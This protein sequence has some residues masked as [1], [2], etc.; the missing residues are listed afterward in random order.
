MQ[1]QSCFGGRLIVAPLVHLLLIPST[2]MHLKLINNPLCYLTDHIIIREVQ[3]KSC[4]TLIKK[5]SFNF[6]EQ[7]MMK[8]HTLPSFQP[9]TTPS[10]R[11]YQF[12][13]SASVQS[14]LLGCCSRAEGVRKR[15]VAGPGH[16]SFPLTS[17]RVRD[18]KP[19][20]FHLSDRNRSL[21]R[22]SVFLDDG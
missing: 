15:S 10:T 12:L 4:H 18:E 2:P 17:I 21:S 9:L 7:C 22:T 14:L 3:L 13:S 20:L 8:Q 16:F 5:C 19:P 6:F 11:P 1:N